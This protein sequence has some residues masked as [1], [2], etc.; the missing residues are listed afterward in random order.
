MVAEP[1][2]VEL[3]NCAAALDLQGPTLVSCAAIAMS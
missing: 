3:L 2:K 1:S